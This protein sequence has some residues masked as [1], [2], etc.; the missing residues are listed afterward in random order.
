[1]EAES[2]TT[3]SLGEKTETPR[4]PLNWASVVATF[5]IPYSRIAATIM[6][7]FVSK[8]ALTRSVYAPSTILCSIGNNMIF[9]DSNLSVFT[10]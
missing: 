1:M 7:S 9:S 5:A 2:Y 8:P 4:T 3:T 6:E 10:Q